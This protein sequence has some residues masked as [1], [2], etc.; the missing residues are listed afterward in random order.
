[1]Y[2]TTSRVHTLNPSLVLAPE[3]ALRFL[4]SRAL[5]SAP[6]GSSPAGGLVQWALSVVIWHYLCGLVTSSKITS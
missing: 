3:S 5:S 6:S 2:A 1:M 4:P